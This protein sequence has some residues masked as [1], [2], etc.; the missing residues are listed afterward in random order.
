MRRAFI[1]GDKFSSKFPHVCF[2]VFVL[3]VFCFIELL[4]CLEVFGF[5]R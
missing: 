4:K 2:Y 5:I 1:L 3:V